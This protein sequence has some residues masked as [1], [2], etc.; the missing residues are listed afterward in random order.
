MC[1]MPPPRTMA[2]SVGGRVDR[3]IV[4][5]G[6]V[7]AEY[8]TKR[9]DMDGRLLDHDLATELLQLHDLDAQRL[10][11]VDLL[12]SKGLMAAHPVFCSPSTEYAVGKLVL[13]SNLSTPFL[14]AGDQV[15]DLEL[16][17]TDVV[18]RSSSFL[19]RGI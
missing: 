11:F 14:A 16:E 4:L 3:P 13:T 18:V 9:L 5:P 1:S 15:A 17:L 7:D 6:G 19:F 2:A 8:V 12:A 10:D